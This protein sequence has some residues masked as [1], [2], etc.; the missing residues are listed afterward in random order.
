[1]AQVVLRGCAS[2]AGRYTGQLEQRTNQRINRRKEFTAAGRV[3]RAPPPVSS[4]KEH[5]NNLHQAPALAVPRSKTSR[6]STGLKR[7]RVKII[8]TPP[9]ADKP[10][11]APTI[12]RHVEA[13]RLRWGPKSLQKGGRRACRALAFDGYSF[14]SVNR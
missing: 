12:A 13:P 5:T 4:R 9:G 2:C 10:V 1:M 14:D 7:S 3:P 8:F 11:Y 6:V